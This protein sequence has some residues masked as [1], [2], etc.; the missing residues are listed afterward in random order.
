M[1]QDESQN[2]INEIETA[3]SDIGV[4]AIKDSDFGI[5]KR[6]LDKKGL[7]FTPFFKATP[8]VFLRNEHP[9]ANRKNK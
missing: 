5:M 9:L 8:H 1:L 2:V 3:F 4:I 6:Y 7:V